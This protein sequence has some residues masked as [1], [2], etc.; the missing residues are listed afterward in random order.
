MSPTNN[1]GETS[2][3][4]EEYHIYVKEKLEDFAEKFVGNDFVKYNSEKII[5]DAVWGTHRFQTHELSIIS[6]PILQRLRQIRQM[7]FVTYVYP[8]A[9]HT[10]FEHTLGTT[11]LASKLFDYVFSK[12]SGLL[13]KPS[14]INNIRMAALFHDIGHGMFSHTSEEIYGCMLDKLIKTEF[15]DGTVNPKPHEFLAYLLLRTTAFKKFFKWLSTTYAIIIDHEEISNYIVG[16]ASNES[17][18]YKVSFVNGS[19]D[20][21]KLDYIYRD[22]KFSGIPLLLDLDRL[23]HEISISDFG[24]EYPDE[25]VKDLTIGLSGVSSL[26]QIV[27]NKMMLFATIYHHQKVKACD[28]MFKSFFEYVRKNKIEIIF[29]KD[30][31]GNDRKLKF[32]NPIDFLWFTDIDFIAE[33]ARTSDPEIHRLIHNIVYRR[34]LKRALVI[35]RKTIDA[36]SSDMNNF[37]KLL[38][39]KHNKRD[40]ELRWRELAKKIWEDAGK[41]CSEHDVWIDL[42]NPPS[43]KEAAATHVRTDRTDVNKGLRKLEEFF[44]TNQWTDQYKAHKLKGHVFA[45]EEHLEAIA[46][47]AQKIF[48]SEYGINFKPEA[49]T[50][51]KNSKA[52]N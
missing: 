22:S 8:S 29:G 41:P 39:T 25:S 48:S 50:F 16:K 28:C 27:F 37:N 34:P 4:D 40:I 9:I 21:D 23:M 15:P 47:S 5:N 45:P 10:R 3:S 43:F 31:D 2:I 38:Y 20:A 17:M 35:S 13:G 46:A 42:P 49:L 12:Q 24:D 30:S 26:E 14:D 19:F 44:P 7:G 11:I 6:L 33:G 52:N 36:N 18:R 1:L 32:D 51:A